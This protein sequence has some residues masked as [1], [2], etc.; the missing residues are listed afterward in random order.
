MELETRTQGDRFMTAQDNRTISRRVFEEFWNAGNPDAFAELMAEDIVFRDRDMGEHRG[1][2]ATRDFIAMY[3]AAF[4]DL[5]FTIEEQIAEG[6]RVA[7]RWTAR[8]TQRGELMGIPPTGRSVTV[9]GITIDRISEG[10]ITESIGSWDAM[11]L[12]QQLGVLASSQPG[13]ADLRATP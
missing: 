2:A 8:G 4:P 1:H 5:R 7:T 11:G 13:G 3:R 6:D 9:S 12:M 10:R